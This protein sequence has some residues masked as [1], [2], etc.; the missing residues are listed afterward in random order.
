MRRP[1]PPDPGRGGGGAVVARGGERADAA[2]RGAA[3]DGCGRRGSSSRSPPPGVVLLVLSPLTLAGR[4]RAASRT[5]GSSPGSRRA[6]GRARWCRSAA[7]SSR[8]AEHGSR[9]GPRG[10]RA[11]RRPGRSPTS[12]SCLARTGLVL[13]RGELGTWLVGERGAL[14]VQARA[15]AGWTAGAFGSPS[16]TGCRAPTGSPTCCWRCER[17]SGVSRRWRIWG[18]RVRRGG[19]G[20]GCRSARGRRSTRRGA[21]ARGAGR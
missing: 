5:R 12:A 16:R 1:R 8:P 14:M 20:A 13:E 4:A 2:P 9:G 17:T 6:G 21:L 19:C 11:A 15:A 7:P 3:V 10:A 18:S